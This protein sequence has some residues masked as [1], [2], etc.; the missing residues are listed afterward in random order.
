MRQLLRIGEFAN[1]GR[2]SVKALRYYEAEGLLRPDHVDPGSGYRY[3]R[4]EQCARLAL[5][6]NLRAAGFSINE[7]ASVINSELGSGTI[8][9]LALEKRDRLLKERAEV[10]D[11]LVVLE[12]L[13]KSVLGDSDDP[14]SAVKLTSAPA[15]RVYSVSAT[16]PTLGRPVTEI[17]EAAEA[18][19]AKADA[20]AAAAPFLLFHDPPSRRKDLSIEVCIPLNDDG[21]ARID[22]KTIN[23]CEQGCSVV[24]A[25]SYSQTEGL[26]RAMVDWIDRAGLAAAGPL[27]EIFHRF[28]ADQTGY[29]LPAAFTTSNRDEYIT[30]LLL[31]VSSSLTG[32]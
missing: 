19:V 32:T 29:R 14:L 26:R 11:K 31:P 16:V 12:T 13:T 20:R 10:D 24:Y 18:A 23:A 6:T 30:E 2:V 7:I 4:I 9:E 28:G 8:L 5:I 17:F 1:L 22:S 3:Y 21:A 15:Q 27:R 25:G